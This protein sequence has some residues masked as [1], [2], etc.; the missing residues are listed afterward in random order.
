MND[1]RKSFFATTIGLAAVALATLLALPPSSITAGP[2]YSDWGLAQ[3]LAEVNSTANDAGPTL[4]RD[5]LSL[6]FQS[7][8]TGGLGMADIWV[9][10]RNSE[11]EPWEPPTN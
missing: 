7:T 5:S 6:Y 8:R 4:S 2:K 9:A 10:R 1:C 11:E 3:P